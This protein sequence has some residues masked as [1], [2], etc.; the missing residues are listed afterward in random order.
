MF[1][2]SLVLACSAL[3]LAGPAFASTVTY[4]ATLSSAS[5]VPPGNST[6]KGEATVTLDTATRKIH[7]DVTFS[8][9]S[10]KV[11]AAHIH[12][13]AP[14]GKNSG[15]L[16]PLGNDPKSP[17]KGSATL[18]AKAAK[19]LESGMTYINIHSQNHPVGAIRGQLEKAK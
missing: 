2:R 13:P 7:Y 17:I 12:G 8:G 19:A 3:M 9:F 5:E 1:R 18:T 6:G 4:K 15:I 16:L 14:V 10:S 11:V